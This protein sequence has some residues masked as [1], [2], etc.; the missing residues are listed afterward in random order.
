[1]ELHFDVH[2]V[3]EKERTGEENARASR[4]YTYV[5]TNRKWRSYRY[6]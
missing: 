6:R 4:Q 5:K 2:E 1:M 3:T